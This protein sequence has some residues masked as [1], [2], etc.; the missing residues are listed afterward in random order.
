L[1]L[2]ETLPELHERLTTSWAVKRP[3]EMSCEEACMGDGLVTSYQEIE[4]CTFE[5][6]GTPETGHM[7][8]FEA[9]A[10]I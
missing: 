5:C 1:R 10:E 6:S 2:T 9:A 8:Q 4:D 7:K 3:E